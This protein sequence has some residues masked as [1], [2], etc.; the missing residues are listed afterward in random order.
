MATKKKLKGQLANLQNDIASFI[1]VID[2]AAIEADLCDEWYEVLEDAT[3]GT[4]IALPEREYVASGGV[5][6]DFSFV[7]TASSPSDATEKTQE[8]L[9][10]A[11]ENALSDI[12][13]G[14]FDASFIDADVHEVD[15]K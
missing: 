14:D 15:L 6:F 5:S 11:V 12:T 2:K 13:L 10:E 3:A 1:A 7:V 8:L 9:E 4:S